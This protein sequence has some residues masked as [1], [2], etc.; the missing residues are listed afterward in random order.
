M[1]AVFNKSGNFI[2]I[3]NEPPVDERYK[4]KDLGPEFIPGKHKYTGTYDHGRVISISTPHVVDNNQIITTSEIRRFV[5]D[6]ISNKYQI[7]DQLN[8]ISRCISASN[9]PLTTEFIEMHNF[10]TDKIE[11]YKKAKKGIKENKSYVLLNDEDGVYEYEVTREMDVFR[12][13]CAE[14]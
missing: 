5:C 2:Y 10:I 6:E 11:H 7:Y 1:Y 12:E 9:I 3:S 4:Y 13:K 8:I 14:I